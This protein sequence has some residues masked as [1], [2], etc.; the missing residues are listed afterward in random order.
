MNCL[1]KCGLWLLEKFLFA[2]IFSLFFIVW[3]LLFAYCNVKILNDNF[4]D[5]YSFFFA[6]NVGL[7][8]ATVQQKLKEK[9]TGINAEE[10]AKKY[11]S[12]VGRGINNSSIESEIKKLDSAWEKVTNCIAQLISKTAILFAFLSLSCIITSGYQY[13]QNLHCIALILLWPFVQYNLCIMIIPWCIRLAL[14]RVVYPLLDIE[15]KQK[16]LIKIKTQYNNLENQILNNLSA[17]K[18]KNNKAKE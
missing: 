5:Y 17:L 12:V 2:L 4:V 10:I 8:F 6:L 15:K 14:K 1:V 18:D 3:W 16:K 9:L 7:S 11:V 13:I